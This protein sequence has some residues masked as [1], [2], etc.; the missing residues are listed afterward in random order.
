L[1]SKLGRAQA[2]EFASRPHGWTEKNIPR[3]AS[4]P[5]QSEPKSLT[6]QHS[7]SEAPMND[8]RLTG[9]AKNLGGKV[10]EGFGQVTG[11]TRTQLRGKA[12]QAEGS[13]QDLYGQAKDAAGDTIQ[14][15]R[16][17]AGDVRDFIR[18]S[19]ETRPYTTAATALVIG[20]LIGRMGRRDAW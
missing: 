9:T 18:E 4:T 5:N 19:I 15:V 8:D 14:A 1:R 10:E 16:D 3:Q 2:K 6:V 17:S 12:R 7:L 20:F 13:V 11:D